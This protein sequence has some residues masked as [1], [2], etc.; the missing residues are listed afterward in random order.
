MQIVYFKGW[1]AA[2][3]ASE[4]DENLR[5]S[6]FITIRWYLGYVARER[7]GGAS[8]QSA[9]VFMDEMLRQRRPVEWVAQRWRAA[10]NWFFENAPK[11]RYRPDP[12]PA[13]MGGGGTHGANG[14]PQDGA[15]EGE[16]GTGGGFADGRRSYAVTVRQYQESVGPEPLIEEA[17]RLMRV[18]HMSY[19]TEETYV[20]W[21]RRWNRFT[22]EKPMDALREDDLKGFLSALAVEEA[23]SASTQRQALNAGVFFL[24]EVRKQELGDFS[25]YVPA[26]P[27]KYYP[28]VY[29]RREVRE[30][31][32]RMEGVAALMA[33][34]QY[35]CGLRI[36]ELCRLR[37]KDLDFERGKVYVR[38]GKGGQDRMVPMPRSIRD[39][40]QEHLVE[41]GQLFRKD[42]A[43]KRRGVYLPSAL[44]RKFRNAGA[45]WEWQWAFPSHA[46]ARDPREPSAP[47]RRHHILPGVYQRALSEAVRAAGIPKRSNS[48][49][50]RHS[51]ATHL[52]ESGT[53]VRTVQQFL[54]H[55]CIETT[56]IYLHVM[57]DQSGQCLSPLDATLG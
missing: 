27:K 32:L 50:L 46:L 23:V 33:Q 22:G 15:A 38:G 8:V 29:S 1:E 28:V 31:L 20:G 25:D 21:L 11:R 47:R 57:E 55:K 35:G 45:S 7:C 5:K 17:L 10:L 9:R 26:N 44:E 12:V 13:S 6:Y 34:L 3:D 24:R 16:E 39:A 18:R 40:L 54:G 36:S 48:H 14:R 37:V 42:R 4:M 51:F 30:V 49:L 56:M 43:E 53:N 41:V 52:L 2:L 19:R